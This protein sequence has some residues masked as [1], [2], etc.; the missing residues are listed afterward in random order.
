MIFYIKKEVFVT[1][2]VFFFFL[3]KSECDQFSIK[4]GSIT[5]PSADSKFGDE[6]TVECDT[7]Y[8][9][10]GDSRIICSAG[11]N[12]S[13]KPVCQLKGTYLDKVLV[14]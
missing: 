12:W 8:N 13:S 5:T 4:N 6:L 14:L 9:L 11:G 3:K 7:G 10:V 1:F 2:Q